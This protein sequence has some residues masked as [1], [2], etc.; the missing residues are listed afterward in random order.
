MFF[1]DDWIKFSL[2]DGASMQSQKAL[3]W[4][5]SE[6]SNAKILQMGDC[7]KV[8][9]MVEAV[10]RMPL[11]EN[12]IV[13]L[14]GGVDSQAACLLLKKAGIKFGIAIAEYDPKFNL[15]DTESAI[16][17]CKV[18][19]FDFTIIK[20][21]ILRFL[22]REL[23]SYVMKYECPSPQFCTHFHFFERIIQELN[24]TCIISGGNSPFLVDG[25]WVFNTSLS[26][27]SWTTFSTKNDFP[28]I[29]NFLC[30]SLD[31]AYPL[32][33]ST[34]EISKVSNL[35]VDR[36]ISKVEGMQRLEIPVIPQKTKFTGFEKLKKHFE[37][38]TGD[39]WTFEKRFRHPNFKLF[40]EYQGILRINDDVAAKLRQ[41]NI[42]YLN[43]GT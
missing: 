3:L 43:L 36:Y 2:Q 38:E 7:N 17:F 19:G 26:Q 20:I 42:D 9:M 12:P 41:S 11:G 29:G 30:W 23:N 37:E 22:S 16:N 15:M 31:I 35:E 10:K 14:S 34:R 13:S 40:P 24:P 6:Q 25:K 18:N 5:F 39:G 27:N 33:I 8:A 32:M 21:N 1:E 28:M 4:E